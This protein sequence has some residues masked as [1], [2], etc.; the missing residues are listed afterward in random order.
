MKVTAYKNVFNRDCSLQTTFSEFATNPA[1][2]FKYF[3]VDMADV[4]GRI[5]STANKDIRTELKR[6]LLPAVKL[7]N[8]GLLSIDIDNIHDLP[9]IKA[10]V[11]R[12]LSENSFC[13]MV[14]ESVSGNIVA[15]FKYECNKE[16]YKFL[17][18]RLY[19]ELALSLGV[20]IDFL[21]DVERLRY[22][23]NPEY[24]YLNE[25]SNTLTEMLKVD[26][27]PQIKTVIP[28]DRAR[29]IRYGSR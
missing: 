7:S 8:S 2:I 26:V 27:L 13:H 28:K 15:F 22:L 3:N 1:S 21:P 24:L 4:L 20:N 12:K 23:S 11:V 5:K 6:T 18:Y 10:L 9:D 14:K 17:Y 16:D 19:L 29:R 25:N